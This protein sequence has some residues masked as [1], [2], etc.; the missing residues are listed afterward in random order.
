MNVAHGRHINWLFEG[1]LGPED[2]AAGSG[3][4]HSG[5]LYGSRRRRLGMFSFPLSKS[6]HQYVMGE[7]AGYPD[8]QK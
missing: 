8:I 7:K 1:L 5:D 3:P 6:S 4:G 2:L